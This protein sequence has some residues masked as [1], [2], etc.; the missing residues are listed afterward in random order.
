MSLKAIADLLKSKYGGVLPPSL[1]GTGVANN[2]AATL[3]RSGNH[4]LTLTTTGATNVTLPT[5]G[6]LAAASAVTPWTPV[7]SCASPGDLNISAYTTQVGVEKR[8]D[9]LMVV[10]FQIVIAALAFTYSTASG[11][12]R[13]TG[14]STA[15]IQSP[16]G[17]AF[18]GAARFTGITKANYTNFAF[19]P[20]GG[21]GQFLGLIASAS[22]QT[23]AN[24]AITDLPS[25]G[26]ITLAGTV[27]YFV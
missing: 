5:S 4:A 23:S 18:F 22:A 1:G 15:A 25:A 27:A 20:A 26:A 21:G 14:L 9:D 8:I 24:V 17:I 2:N 13:I 7:L 6:T 12:L 19:S 10:S 16:S 11:N 3:T